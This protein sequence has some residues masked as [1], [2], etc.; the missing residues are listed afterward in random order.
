MS[1]TPNR[2]RRDVE[3]SRAPR[4]GGNHPSPP[5]SSR[6]PWTWSEL[7]TVWDHY[8]WT[9]KE[10]AELL[11]GRSPKS[12][13]RARDRYGRYRTGRVPICA[14]CGERPVWEESPHA[15]HLGLCMSCYLD[16]EEM[17]LKDRKRNDALRQ[18]RMRERRRNG[19]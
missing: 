9:A 18:R 16:E 5:S 7:C 19:R 12:V 17:R 3:N 1:K 6:Q 13:E 2:P 8:D 14:R 10:V 4:D 11:P 15:R